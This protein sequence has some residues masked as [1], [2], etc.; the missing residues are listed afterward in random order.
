MSRRF[1][2]ERGVPYNWVDIDLDPRGLDLVRDVSN[3]ERIIPVVVLADGAVLVEPST[4]ELDRKL[5]VAR[6]QG[7][8]AR[9][10]DCAELV[11]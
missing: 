4:A 6:N 2:D 5:G 8:L 7:A 1:L 9:S 3:G 10:V 11:R